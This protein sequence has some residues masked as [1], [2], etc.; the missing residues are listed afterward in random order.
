[1]DQHLTVDSEF[2]DT[3]TG[4]HRERLRYFTVFEVR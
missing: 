4:S 2:Q 1:M 3:T